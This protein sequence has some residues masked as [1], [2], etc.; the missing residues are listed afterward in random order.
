MWT[1]DWRL[2]EL[3]AERRN[4]GAKRYNRAQ[5]KK[6]IAMV[7]KGTDIKVADTP[8]SG[9]TD[10]RIPDAYEDWLADDGVRFEDNA[11]GTSTRVGV[12]SG[13]EH[14]LR[15]YPRSCPHVSGPRRLNR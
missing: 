7:M 11:V 5:W 1:N 6:G 12:T 4:D 13:K 2:L 9:L 8:S 14:P 10:F 15:F 3:G